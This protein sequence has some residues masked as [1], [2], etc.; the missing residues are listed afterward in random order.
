MLCKILRLLHIS[1]LSKKKLN[2]E[3]KTLEEFYWN[4]LDQWDDDCNHIN[5]EYQERRKYM[6]R[7]KSRTKD[8]EL[9]KVFDVFMD[10]DSLEQEG[11]SWLD[12]DSRGVVVKINFKNRKALYLTAIFYRHNEHWV[13]L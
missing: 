6:V 8:K 5:N 11:W 9:Q 2:R 7:E 13:V 4:E 12:V 1:R 10:L 3:R